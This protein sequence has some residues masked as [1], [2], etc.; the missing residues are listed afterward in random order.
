MKGT[1]KGVVSLTAAL[2]IGMLLAGCGGGGDSPEEV[3]E[4]F[5]AAAAD[6][7]AE[8]MCELASEASAQSGAEENDAETC[9]EGVQSSIDA[10]NLD[11][12]S[13]LV[14]GVEVGEA[15]IDGDAATVAITSAEGEEAEIDLVKEDDEWKVDFE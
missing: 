7:D 3:V 8:K 1:G 4:D 14:E 5:Y 11:E 9:E 2:A 12:F 10:G 13:A 15:T 6:G